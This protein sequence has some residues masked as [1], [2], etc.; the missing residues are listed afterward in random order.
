MR[1]IP[2]SIAASATR[3]GAH[4]QGYRL[5]C[6]REKAPQYPAFTPAKIGTLSLDSDLESILDLAFGGRCAL[7]RR[8]SPPQNRGELTAGPKKLTHPRR[9][10]TGVRVCFPPVTGIPGPWKRCS[11]AP[12]EQASPNRAT[13][14]AF[15]PGFGVCLRACSLHAGSRPAFTGLGISWENWFV[16]VCFSSR[17]Q[18]GQGTNPPHLLFICCCGFAWGD[19]FFLPPPLSKQ[20]PRGC[21]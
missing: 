5:L 6:N 10:D 20:R 3:R 9:P 19:F 16:C 11:A 21:L 2:Q 18:H 8:L 4:P 12:T 1:N 17:P 7:Q 15:N 13:G 14:V